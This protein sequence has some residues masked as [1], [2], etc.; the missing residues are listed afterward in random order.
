[1]GS[2]ADVIPFSLDENQV[3]D[4]GGDLPGSHSQEVLWGRACPTDESTDEPVRCLLFTKLVH[5]HRLVWLRVVA[6]S[7]VP[8]L[9]SD[10]HP[11]V[12]CVCRGR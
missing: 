10:L 3:L 2:G 8:L 6:L 11:R 9:G 12:P 5:I 1:M 4:R 7:P